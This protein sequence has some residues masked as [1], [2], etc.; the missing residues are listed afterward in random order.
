MRHSELLD[1][2]CQAM[3]AEGGAGNKP[4]SSDAR[5]HSFMKTHISARLLA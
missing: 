1:Y 5:H 4:G 2:L 3:L